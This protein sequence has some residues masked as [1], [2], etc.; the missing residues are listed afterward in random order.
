MCRWNL[1]AKTLTHLEALFLCTSFHSNYTHS[2]T[3][4]QTTVWSSNSLISSNQTN[5]PTYF[6]NLNS[7]LLCKQMEIYGQGRYTITLKNKNKK[8]MYSLWWAFCDFRLDCLLL[9]WGPSVLDKRVGIGSIATHLGP[10]CAQTM[11]CLPKLWSH[12]HGRRNCYNKANKGNT[13]PVRQNK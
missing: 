10:A 6:P 12:A 8:E 5:I 13:L 4:L 7:V 1:K 9:Y 11:P 2:S 3:S